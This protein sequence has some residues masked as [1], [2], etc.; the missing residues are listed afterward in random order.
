MR[1]LISLTAPI[2]DHPANR[3][4]DLLPWVYQD[5]IDAKNAE[6]EAKDAA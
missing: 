3:I 1:V 2:Q 6:A 4:N 5:M